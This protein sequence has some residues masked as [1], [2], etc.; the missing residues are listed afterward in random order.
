MKQMT[1]VW[2][3]EAIFTGTVLI[4]ITLAGSA[5]TPA[6]AQDQPL[7]D[8]ARKVRQEKTTEQPAVKKFDNDN[9]P[10]DQKISVVGNAAPA[11]ADSANSADKAA[12]KTDEK[13]PQSEELRQKA[14]AQ[15][16]QKISSQKE[17]IDMLS[18]EL[19]VIQR[20]YKLRAAAFYGDVGERLR[21][22]AAW[23]KEDAQYKQQIADKQK[24]LDAAKQHLDDMQEDARKAG[25]PNSM[26]E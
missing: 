1:N 7:G 9:L 17:Q 8:Y 16:K 11:S 15:W 13:A 24:A 2:L 19:D 14:Y 6:Q 3:S 10:T 20:E 12:P 21:N 26:R 4:G 5:A 25:V 22:S 23:D 18:R